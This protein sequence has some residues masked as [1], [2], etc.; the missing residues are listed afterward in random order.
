MIESLSRSDLGDN[1]CEGGIHPSRPDLGDNVCV[2]GGGALTPLDLT[3]K[4]PT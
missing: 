1:V 4:Y 2:C 3:S